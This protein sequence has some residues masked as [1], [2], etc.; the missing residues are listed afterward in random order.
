MA[1]KYLYSA[2]SEAP[3]PPDKRLNIWQRRLR[4]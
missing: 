1:S 3:P 4:N 2:K